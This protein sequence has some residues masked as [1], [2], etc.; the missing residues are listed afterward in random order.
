MVD[1]N[2]KINRLTD[3]D[4]AF[5]LECEQE[6]RCR[7]TENDVE[8]WSLHQKEMRSPPI[9]QSFQGGR[10]PYGGPSNWRG[11]N[12]RGHR[13]DQHRPPR[14][15]NHHNRRPYDRNYRRGGYG[16][17]GGGSDGFQNQRPQ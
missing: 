17:R 12:H 4:L 8:F 3:D 10:R 13:F 15:F 6:F 16:G 14:H 5:L 2:R 9:V 1:P 7:F 11:N